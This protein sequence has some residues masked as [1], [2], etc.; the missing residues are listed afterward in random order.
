MALKG[1]RMEIRLVG[2]IYFPSYFCHWAD[3]WGM[4]M[5]IKNNSIC[6]TDLKSV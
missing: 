3:G 6:K 1:A 4:D 2:K 5:N